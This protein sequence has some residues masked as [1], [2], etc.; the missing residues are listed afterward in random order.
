MIA[1][2][3]HFSQFTPAEYLD[4][5]E[6]QEFRHEYADGEIYAMTGGTLTHS[7]IAAQFMRA[8]GNHLE[9]GN[10]RLFTSDAK[11]QIAASNSFFYPDISVTCDERDRS[12]S[13]FISYPCLIIEVL[14]PST[15]AYDRGDKF[16]LYRRS[17]DLQEYVLVSTKK[18]CLDLYRRDEGGRWEFI[19]YAPGDLVELKSINFSCPIERIYKGIVLNSES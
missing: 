2:P 18:I 7:E 19:S 11:V 3:E 1:L 14:S 15:E 13:K 5:E 8:L 16:S 9:D 6:Q 10:C 17:P 4:W 12:A